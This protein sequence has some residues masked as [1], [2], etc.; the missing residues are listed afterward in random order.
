MELIKEKGVKEYL[1][2]LLTCFEKTLLLDENSFKRIFTDSHL[3]YKYFWNRYYKKVIKNRDFPGDFLN[4][5]DK[6]QRMV[7][8]YF[9]D[10]E[11]ADPDL[12]TLQKYILLYWFLFSWNF[13]SDMWEK[14]F[15]AG[16]QKY[17]DMCPKSKGM[18]TFIN[19]TVICK[20]FLKL[21]EEL[22]LKMLEFAFFEY[23]DIDQEIDKALQ[24]RR[25]VAA[26]TER[27]TAN[28]F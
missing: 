23:Q 6:S 5:D 3:G 20:L 16:Y 27:S 10:Y 19:A 25:M 21:P 13:P 24:W 28:A 26:A 8:G 7:V 9:T 2:F 12:V 22:Q 11:K 1:Q 18:M 14:V 4:M 17:I 15:G